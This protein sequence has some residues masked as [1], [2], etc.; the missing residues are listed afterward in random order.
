MADD[1][2]VN[3]EV[4]V[5]QL[6]LLGLEADLAE[7]GAEALAAVARA[8]PWHGAARPAHAGDGRLDLARAIR[9]EEAAPGLPRTALVAVTANALKG[10]DERCYAAGMDG[11]LAKP[12]AL[13]TLARVLGRWLP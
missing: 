5:R 8:A 3:R 13:D 12:V 4:L 9:Q 10:E 1:H 11:F 6:G 2:P 7:D